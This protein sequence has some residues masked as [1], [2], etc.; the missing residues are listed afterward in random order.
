MRSHAS[1][2]LPAG[3]ES[4]PTGIRISVRRSSAGL[5]LP[6]AFLLALAALALLPDCC[7]RNVKEERAYYKS[8]NRSRNVDESLLHR[9]L[10]LLVKPSACSAEELVLSRWGLQ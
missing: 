2:V 6:R 1:A 8:G 5:I 7:S 9:T 10:N 4:L 3:I